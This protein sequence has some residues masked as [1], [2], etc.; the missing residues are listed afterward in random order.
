MIKEIVVCALAAWIVTYGLVF[1]ILLEPLRDAAGVSYDRDKDG[2]A[3]ERWGANKLAELLNCPAC[4]GFWI[5]LV[6]AIV[7]IVGA[8]R[9]IEILAVA[10]ALNLIIRW[11]M[12]QKTNARWWQ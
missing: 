7:W 4:T 12:S 5:S 11:W 8:K 2:L 3:T 9:V 6:V 1:S 10:G